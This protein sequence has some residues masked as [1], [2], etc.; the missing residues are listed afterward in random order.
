MK[1]SIID[2]KAPQAPQLLVNSLKETGFAVLHNHSVPHHLFQQVTEDWQK[3]FASDALKKQ[4]FFD[5]T[6]CPQD[7][8]MPTENAKGEVLNDLKEFYQVYKN[9]RMPECV[10]QSTW[11]LFDSLYA[12]GVD[13]LMW[14]QAFTPL[15]VKQHFSCP[16][17]DMVDPIEQTMMR[18]VHY[19]AQ[20]GA[21]Q[22]GAIRA[23]AH[24]D[25]NILTVLPA[26]GEPGLEAQD[27]EGNWHAVPTDPGMIII[28]SGD[29]LEVCSQ[30]YY[31]ATKHRVRNP[32]AERMGNARFAF[33]MFVHPKNAI[34][35]D[36]NTG[37]THRN[38]LIKRMEEIGLR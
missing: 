10:N 3:F 20:T 36:V 17:P 24:E 35:L 18:I 15:S 7:G 13:M 32:S 2:Y 30:G 19:P 33:P 1:I 12:I 31:K 8:Y 23:A 22:A 5:K 14:I 29:P 4:F 9:G 25:I 11:Q 26:S 34:V 27:L 28:N 16:L 37:L 38:F 21:E 6:L